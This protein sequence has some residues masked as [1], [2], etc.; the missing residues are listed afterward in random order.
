MAKTSATKCKFISI[1]VDPLM[2]KRADWAF[3]LECSLLIG[4]GILV[5]G[6]LIWAFVALGLVGR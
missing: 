6:Y 3:V 1:G 5:F 4:S 2:I